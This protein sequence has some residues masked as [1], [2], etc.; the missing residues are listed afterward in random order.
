[1]FIPKGVIIT[2]ELIKQYIKSC[3]LVKNRIFELKEIESELRKNGC[4]DKIEELNLEHRIRLLYTE[5]RQTQETTEYLM[6]Y[7]RRVEK[8]AETCN[9]L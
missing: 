2:R 9:L 3:E 8:L 6:S 5:H 7:L 4:E 1:M